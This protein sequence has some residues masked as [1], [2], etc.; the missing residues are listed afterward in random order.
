MVGWFRYPGDQAQPV[1]FDQIFYG[2]T[3]LYVDT[4]TGEANI[5]L[6]SGGHVHQATD[7]VPVPGAKAPHMALASVAPS[8]GT[9]NTTTGIWNATTPPSGTIAAV[10]SAG[11]VSRSVR[12]EATAGGAGDVLLFPADPKRLSVRHLGLSPLPPS[13]NYVLIG[14]TA[15]HPDNH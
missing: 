10:L 5:S 13:D 14:A 8:R 12:I 6:L 2:V 3:H 11:Q 15:A 4:S 7:R 9:F 1:T